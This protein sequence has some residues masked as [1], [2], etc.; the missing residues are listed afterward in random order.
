[1]RLVAIAE[2]SGKSTT[3]NEATEEVNQESYVEAWRVLSKVFL[4]WNG[5]I[6]RSNF[7]HSRCFLVDGDDTTTVETFFELLDTAL[8]LLE[9]NSLTP[10]ADVEEC[11]GA[12]AYVECIC[13]C[14]RNIISHNKQLVDAKLKVVPCSDSSATENAVVVQLSDVLLSKLEELVERAQK[15]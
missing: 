10:Y 8:V 3:F 2:P 6:K 4:F 7:M 14:V 13:K 15:Q 11:K 5:Q 1:M 12:L 9:S